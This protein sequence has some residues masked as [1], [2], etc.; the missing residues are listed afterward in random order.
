LV[1]RGAR[2]A[3]AGNCIACHTAPGG[4]SFAGGLALPTPFGTIYSTNITPDQE[5][6]IGRWSEA[7]FI[8]ALRKGVD[9]EG[10][11]LYPA[12]PYDHFTLV[13]DD[14]DRALYAY[15]MTRQPVRARAP[16]NRL[17]FP[18]G[19]RPLIAGWKLLYFKEGPYRAD[20]GKDELWNRGA[21]LAEGLAHC[22]AC[23]TPRNALGAEDRDRHFA[24]GESEG[25]VAYP[26]DA[27]SPAPLPW[28]AAALAFYL[29][30]GWHEA[31]GVSR[32]PMA[33]VTGN[34]AGL[35][36][37]DIAGIARYV[38][39]GMGRPSAQRQA[40]GEEVKA[41]IVDAGDAGGPEADQRPPDP[42]AERGRGGALYEASC[43]G[44]HESRRPQPFGGLDFRLS[45]A[46]SADDPQNIVNVM[47][48]GLPPADGEASA[49]MPAFGGAFEDD[50]MVEILGYLRRRFT[51]QP[52]WRDLKKLVADTRSGAHPVTVRPADGIERSPAH[53]GAED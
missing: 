30:H 10:R 12:F 1:K 24:G 7:A 42:S 16:A 26:I 3:A 9:R 48:F 8:R 5:T 53:I 14:D 50:D 46:V 51:R 19:F 11:H 44:C 27:G 13:S 38:A 37:A 2:L 23:H 17:T 47:M 29:R 40:R 28:D 20:A 52:P 43:A 15:L 39:D 41:A 31:H 6:G 32:G 33:E 49:V 22:G 4:K 45:T 36:D 18:L 35:P 21:Y 34:L 25:W